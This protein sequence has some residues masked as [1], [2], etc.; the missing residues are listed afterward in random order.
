[1][2][3]TSYY[4]VPPPE[5]LLQSI[6]A[7]YGKNDKALFL[8]KVYDK[9]SLKL[10]EREVDVE[11][12]KVVT[13]IAAGGA[14]YEA[15]GLGCRSDEEVEACATS[16]VTLALEHGFII[17][18]IPLHFKDFRKHIVS[19]NVAVAA[20][21]FQRLKHQQE[22]RPG[23]RTNAI[24]FACK[25]TLGAALSCYAYSKLGCNESKIGLIGFGTDLSQGFD[26]IP[27]S[28]LSRFSILVLNS[29]DTAVGNDGR[30]RVEKL[31]KS[32]EMTNPVEIY[33]RTKVYDIGKRLDEFGGKNPDHSWYNYM[34]F[35]ESAMRIRNDVFD[36]ISE[37]L[38]HT[39]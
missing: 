38:E 19:F 18:I 8:K 24:L 31:L 28:S 5:K 1:M 9:V 25:G 2:F 3:S 33:A 36:E 21:I 12:L 30:T 15:Y 37:L 26:D 29:E 39:S 23:F 16:Q 20:L 10:E 34:F 32:L 6:R 7:S 22:M 14:P 13:M 27:I 4:Q 17:D 11:K 35:N